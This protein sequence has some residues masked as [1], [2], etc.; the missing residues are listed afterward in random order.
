MNMLETDKSVQG[1]IGG[2][3]NLFKQ[4]VE[5]YAGRTKLEL[6]QYVVKEGI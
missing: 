2:Q 5:A 1:D 3:F 6:D 4:N